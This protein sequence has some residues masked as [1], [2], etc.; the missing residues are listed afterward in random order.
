[1][2]KL[3]TIIA[4]AVV[5]VLV[6]TTIVLS[7]A[8][9]NYQPQLQN[10]PYLM[11]I[12]NQEDKTY[13][14]GK[15]F[16]QQQPKENFEKVVKLFN[17]SFKQSILASMLNGNLSNK[18]EI[19]YKGTTLP[20]KNAYKVEFKYP[21]TLLMLNGKAFKLNENEPDIKFEYLIFYVEDGVGF[22]E[23]NMYAKVKIDD[24]RDGYYQITTLANTKAL[25][26]FVNQLNYQ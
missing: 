2:K 11:V 13:Q 17:D 23:F 4:L 1:M 26:D 6:V 3:A 18:I 15:G 10:Q 14:G 5:G 19:E 24:S 21:S 22:A 12:T 8:K 16:S 9:K 7:V 25:Y 20:A